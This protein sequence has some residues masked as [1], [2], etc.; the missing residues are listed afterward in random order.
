M[1]SDQVPGPTT[2]VLN[3]PVAQNNS[4]AIV[5]TL[6]SNA[7]EDS[8]GSVTLND[9]LTYS[10]T[11]TND[12]STTLTNVVVSDALL[13][14]NSNSCASVAPS[15]TCVL[16]GTYVVQQSDVDAGSIS[17]TG[18]VVSDQV[19]GPTTDVLNTPVIQTASLTINDVTVVEGVGLLFTVSL[20]N[21]IAGGFSVTTN[22]TDI[23]ATGG[24][25]YDNAPQV[26]NFVGNAGETQQFTVT[27]TDDAILEGTETFTVT[28][29]SSNANVDD[30]DTGN[31]TINDN[32]AAAVTVDDVTQTE[33]GNLVFTVTLDNEVATGAFTVTTGYV[34]VTATGGTDYDNSAQVLN[35]VGTAGETQQ[36]TVTTTD[37][38][39][40]E[41]TE[42][43]TVTLT[44]SNA[45]VDDSDTGTGTINDNDFS[46]D[47]VDDNF[48]ATPIN[49]SSG[50]TTA[51]V[52]SNDTLNG[53]P[54]ADSDVTPSIT[55]NGGL[56]GVSINADGTLTIPSGSVAGSY[57]IAYQ[58]C[59]TANLINCDT[60]DVTVVVVAN[61]ANLSVDDITQTEGGDLVFTVLVD[62]ALGSAFDV[63]VACIDGTATGGSAPGPGIDYDDTPRVLN[64]N[65]LTAG[66]SF[67]ITIPSYTDTL[68]EGDET[69][70]V[71]MSSSSPL[72]NDI[73]TGLGTILNVN[74]DTDGDGP[75]DA[76]EGVGDRDGDG[77][78]DFQ[79]FDPTG[80]FYC[81]ETGQIIPGGTVAFT[82]AGAGTTSFVGGLNGSNGFYQVLFSGADTYTMN[83]TPPAGTILSPDLTRQPQPGAFNP[84]A[85]PGLVSLGSNE[86]VA[87]GFLVDFTAAANPWYQQ[88]T[89]DLGD[90]FILNNN[91]PLTNCAGF[92][93]PLLL[94]KTATP[95][96]VVIGDLVQYTLQIENSSVNSFTTLDVLDNI[97]GGF[98]YVSD[99][100]LLI[101]AGPDA[102][103]NTS[104]DIESV[105]S[106]TGSDPITFEN[107][108]IAT[109]ETVLIRYLLRVSSGVVEGQ[110]TNIAQVAGVGG[111][112]L[113]NEAR[114]T[115]RVTQDPILQKTTIIG[116]VFHDRDGD[117]WQDSAHA[118]KVKIKSNHFGWEGHDLGTIYGRTSVLD[119]I[120]ENQ[121]AVRMP[122]DLQNDNS[123]S[124]ESAEGTLIKVDNDGNLT[125][126]YTGDK[127]KGLTGQDLTVSTVRD[128]EEFVITITNHGLQEVGIPGVRLATV[129]GLLVET[130]QYGRYHLADIDGGRWERGRNFI[131]KVDPTTL[132][133]GAKF[134]TEN[135]RVL[136]ITQAL[137]SK[138]N[139]GV[140]LPA[141]DAKMTEREY[142]AAKR[143]EREVEVLETRE[144]KD[145][146]DPI[147][148]RSGKANVSQNALN[149]LQQEI[150]RLKDKEKVVIRVVGHA[151]S[152]LLSEKTKAKF[153]DNHG[154]A[155][156]RAEQVARILQ[157]ELQLSD[158]MIAIEEYGADNPIATNDT[159]EGRAKNRRTE[160]DVVYDERYTKTVI[161]TDYTPTD[162]P[163]LK[164]ESEIPHG[165]AIWA[166]ED[167]A[168]IDPRLNVTAQN[169]IIL[170]KGKIQDSIKFTLYSNYIAFINRWELAI[171]AAH[172]RDL[173]KPIDVMSGKKFTFTDTIEWQA[174]SI[175]AKYFEEGESLF[176]V[177][178][179]FDK[180]ERMDET[181]P[182]PLTVANEKIIKTERQDYEDKQEEVAILG[183]GES[184]LSRQAIPISGSRVRV[185]GVDLD[186]SYTITVNDE[187]VLV[188]EDGKFVLEQH[189]PIGNHHMHVKVNDGKEIDFERT[190]DVEVTGKYMFMV[191]LA[192]LTV[193]ENSLSGSVEPLGDD[194]HFDEKI[195]VD[196]RIAFYLKGKVKGK[197]LVTAQ[198]DTTEDEIR[199]LGD[200]LEEED[201]T[202][203]FR[204][205]DPDQFYAVYG[206][207]STTIDDTD[208]Q[209]AIY[210]RVDWDKSMALW[211]NYN[212]DLTGTEFAQYN[213]SLYGAK[214]EHRNV[215]TTKFGENKHEVHLFGS[216][217]QTAAA[218]NE[219]TATGG[220]LYYL[221]DTDVVQGSEK[222]WVE[223][224]ARDTE[225]LVE[226]VTLEHGRDYDIDYIQ[227]RI[228][229]TRPLT[230]F[231]LGSGQ[232]IIK[233]TPLDGN[234]VFLLADYEYRPDA[235]SADDITTGGRGKAWLNDYIALG[236]TYVNEDRD[237][238]D[239]E[240]KG[241]D[242]TLRAGKGTYIKLEY[243]ES[244]AK[245]ADNNFISANGGI[246]FTKQNTLTDDTDG[247][248]VGV[249]ARIN[250][251]ELSNHE[252]YIMGWWKD[253]DAGFSSTARLDD[254]IE[255][256]DTGVEAQWQATERL[257]LTA[258]ATQLDKKTQ[259]KFSAISVYG[260]YDVTGKLSVGAEL[261]YEDDEDDTGI[262]AD[263]EATL[264]GAE[265]RYSITEHTDVYTSGQ[266]VVDDKGDY[267]DNDLVTVGVET[268]VNE[269]LALK[270]ELATGD[271]GD[272]VVMGMEYAVTPNLNI[273]LD[274]G[275][276]SGAT[277][278]V[279]TNYTTANGLELYGS[280]ATDPDRTDGGESMFT[281]GSRKRYGNKLSIYTENQ[282]GEGEDEQSVAR[283][284]GLDYDLTDQWRLSASFQKNDVDQ[285]LGDIDRRAATIGSSFKGDDLKFGSVLE[286]R[287]DDNKQTA[288]DATQ[289]ITSNTIEWQ[290]SESL[291]WLGK[292]ELSTTHSDANKSDEA[293][294]AEI[295]LGFAYRP[296]FNDRL[297]ILGKY[298]YIYDLA[299][300]G[301][302][303]SLADQRS[304]VFALEGIYD[305]TQKWEV[306]SKL[307]Y[308]TGDTRISRGSGPWFESG[309]HL[310]VA[311]ARYHM[312]KK[313]DAL[314]EYRWLETEEQ[315]DD[316]DGALVGVY[317]HVGEHMKIG[318]GYNFTDFSD[319]L[320]D[321]DY[322]SHGWFLDI[323]GKY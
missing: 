168:T 138:F 258:R 8:S 175:D 280:Y 84:P 46:I 114:A 297:N 133:E 319:D 121:L 6:D 182:R 265:V 256:I 2:D 108:D 142:G 27:T 293:R 303:T 58:I 253:R 216:E 129:E 150:T 304:H 102:V 307:A 45:N 251:A 73:D 300:S 165:G 298:T 57:T 164:R 191:G 316:K 141:Q 159:A 219:F 60:A 218:H 180:D 66:E 52:Y 195:W 122:L 208:S 169:G 267:E 18:S 99:S 276:G 170:K 154:L 212:T 47:A 120:E 231:D 127:R 13:T 314:F 136:R 137:M 278:Q 40:L 252:G 296:V 217:A 239:Y 14:P 112:R 243:A 315:D 309:A 192:N 98:S 227:G 254:G 312:L 11:V 156:A 123:F 143:I 313:W 78:P 139:F 91:I 59:E 104:D 7:D 270:G 69:F 61:A 147:Y 72:V 95:D 100:A 4:L 268:Q 35:F 23:T 50:G 294:Y 283:T 119:S 194:D 90:A 263:G 56:P 285:D 3:T 250:F 93:N 157:Q 83:I 19:P 130:D 275:F 25:D 209:G 68:I 70:T 54:F 85:G 306:G 234:D 5:K 190:L 173:I 189:L 43:F 235:F 245:Q 230:Q 16:T 81:S 34:D 291:R 106:V 206:D 31:G 274:A 185:N 176:Y 255:T 301:Q 321:N 41:G 207:D 224:R 131:I 144:I 171:Y 247:E 244:D 222:L 92:A 44:S 22:Y 167:P 323:T 257:D 109:N 172:D 284:Y 282:F 140:K 118:T 236:G 177:L 242:I 248:A 158:E 264:A 161:E 28:L 124:I 30:S 221:R 289:W 262:G 187:K 126:E 135:P 153:G 117:G 214:L 113:S 32:D 188:D 17:N 79:D 15:A 37:D 38:A 246:S 10:V 249:E 94:T 225:Q 64:F 96:E 237:G 76:I 292:V 1:V 196:G 287:E 181:A 125:E 145:V 311:R 152:R 80:Y 266:V 220:S 178:R 210:L 146:V 42:T 200:R 259:N 163:I 201:P 21:L 226:I 193:G 183:Y 232:A 29:T 281:F 260:D 49:S 277:N 149:T 211:G 320:T 197:Y 203:V 272:A 48:S 310:A 215:D 97:P 115:V 286:Y 12:G 53:L 318:A 174:Q 9:T 39:I 213:R 204:R 110:Y 82:A 184:N 302:D 238:V 77:I 155:K 317:R 273:S 24:I 26:L 55:N 20:D 279:G 134:T 116:K 202:E 74:P 261:R 290:Q 162:K 198:L 62:N 269:R 199:N 65:G 67:T 229:L 160:I 36:F 111:V 205:L 63:T 151:D 75:D 240:L 105:I 295:D 33:G 51:T 241:T 179:V 322:D 223:V 88:F 233:D 107:V 101:T 132:P 288:E 128:G 86:N 166:V 186:R 89:I 228:I 87:T 271:R 103:I 308:K 299:S 148:F 305:L 71:N